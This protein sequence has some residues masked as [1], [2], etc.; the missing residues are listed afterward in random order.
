MTS[1]STLANSHSTDRK[2]VQSRSDLASSARACSVAF[3]RRDFDSPAR[4]EALSV[5]FTGC[6]LQA[7]L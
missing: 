1:P 6:P 5:G 3:T 4:N 7:L 2:S